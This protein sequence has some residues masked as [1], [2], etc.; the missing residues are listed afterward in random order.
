MRRAT[1]CVSLAVV[2]MALLSVPASA[3]QAPGTVA[4]PEGPPPVAASPPA[5]PSTVGMAPPA[6]HPLIATPDPEREVP[7]APVRAA[8]CS[9][10]ARETDGSTTCIGIPGESRAARR[11]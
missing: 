5:A 8:P 2:Q 6:S 1:F 3:E 11:R 9:V 4:T 10:S 7:L